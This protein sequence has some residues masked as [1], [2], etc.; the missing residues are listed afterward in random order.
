MVG[1]KAQKGHRL[2]SLLMYKIWFYSNSISFFIFIELFI[3]SL[4]LSLLQE[5][6]FLSINSNTR[7]T[8]ES[9]VPK[10]V[11]ND[12]LRRPMIDSESNNHSIERCSGGWHGN[13]QGLCA[14]CNYFLQW[15]DGR[16][17]P[18][19]QAWMQGSAAFLHHRRRSA[20]LLFHASFNTTSV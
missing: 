14:V 10:M 6:L 15:M 17:N 13:S 1:G 19:Q 7:S 3:N 5:A 2:P 16:P 18:M 4:F 20:A 9:K 8:K 12:R 11:S